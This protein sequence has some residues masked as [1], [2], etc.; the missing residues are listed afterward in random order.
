MT[1]P[2]NWL[3]EH[4]TTVS[5][6]AETAKVRSSFGL[7][8][9]EADTKTTAIATDMQLPFTLSLSVPL[10]SR[11]TFRGTQKHVLRLWL[12]LIGKFRLKMTLK[13]ILVFTYFRIVTICICV[14]D[15]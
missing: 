1:A 4:F 5:N 13:L 10:P 14:V 2:V 15:V 9:T 6:V 8:E 3:P 12:L 11:E 7:R